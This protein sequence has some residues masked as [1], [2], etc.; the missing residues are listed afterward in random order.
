VIFQNPDDLAWFVRRGIVSVE[1]ALLIRGA[2]VDVNLFRPAPEPVGTPIVVLASRLLWDKGI[3]EFVEASQRLKAK[4]LLCRF[5]L[6]GIP[7]AENPN[8]IPLE[9]IRG[10]QADDLI[11]WWGLRDDM[12]SVLQSASV[13]ALPSYRGRA[14][15]SLARSGSMWKG[16]GR[17]KRPRLPRDCAGRSQW[18]LSAST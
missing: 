13:V 4:G 3:A 2:G 17:F 16:A 8:S 6:V 14:P 11:E 10:W 15:Q 12:A 5:V 18:A 9:T 1:Q 7:D